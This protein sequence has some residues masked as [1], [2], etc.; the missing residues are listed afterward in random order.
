MVTIENGSV[1]FMFFRPDAKRVSIAGDFND[2]KPDDLKMQPVGKG[3]WGC[4]MSLPAGEYRFRYCAD[5]EW[6]ADYAA[7]GLEPGSF[8]MDSLLVV[9]PKRLSVAPVAE[10][11]KI[12]KT[13]AA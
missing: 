8:G 5:G 6:F 11:M 10:P 1:D 2:W 4:K 3:H 9:A 7:C 13:F 12:E